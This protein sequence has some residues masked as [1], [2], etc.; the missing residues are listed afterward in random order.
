MGETAESR[1]GGRVRDP[2]VEWDDPG[3]RD[4]FR[5]SAA[6]VLAAA[7]KRLHPEARLGIGPAIEDRFYYDFDVPGGLTAEDLGPIEEEMARVVAEDSPFIREELSRE[8]AISLFDRLGE[9][10][11]VEL[12]KELPEG[13]PITIYRCGGF[14][15]LCAGPHVSSTGEISAFKLLALA[16]AYW[17]GHEANPML[18]RIYGTAFPTREGLEEYLYRLE[19]AKKRDHRVLGPQ[20]DLF[21]LHDEGQGFAFWHHKGLVLWR[22]LEDFWREEH[23]KAGYY[24]IRTPIILK[25][26][27]WHRSGHWDHYRDNMYFTRI[28]D[29][30]HAIKPMNCPGSMLLYKM[31]LHSYREFPLRVAELGLVHRHELSGVLHGL[32]R[33]RNFTQDDA[34]IFMTRDQVKDEIIGVIELTDRI[35]SAFGLGYNVE[36]STRPE[37]SMG[38][39]WQ[40]QIATAALEDALLEKGVKYKVNPGDGAFYGPK[41]DFH[42]QDSL[43]RTWQCGTIQLDFQMPERFDL[44]YVG[45]D[46]REHR[47]VMLH[48]TIYGAMERFIGLLIEEYAGAFPVWLAPVQVR[49]LPI[50]DRHQDYGRQVEEQMRAKGLRT[51]L[52]LRNEKIGF[53]IRSAEVEKL[54]YMAV[55]GD[56]EVRAEN[57][58][59][60]RRGDGDLGAMSVD[61]FAGRVL[62][63]AQERTHEL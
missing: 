38:E 16:G 5:H 14:V 58:S 41:I 29:Q 61:D 60:R 63:E 28:D 34:H 32:L 23:R 35:Y 27:L 3:V 56:R 50:A 45:P 8:E 4:V 43:G 12:A 6:H 53:K 21:S 42:I 25:E 59:V 31:N 2:R 33:V 62:R 10:Y 49:V 24:E 52:D 39:D 26:E 48:R 1:G 13:V 7:V 46:G 36:L 51:E 57:V 40:W 9:P 19:E 11:K 22:I 37:N 55:I 54:P 47:P 20:L 18:Q 44:T 17:K 15:D 30:L